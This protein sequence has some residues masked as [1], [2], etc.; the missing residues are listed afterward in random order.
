MTA[1]MPIPVR[2]AGRR[3]N[4]F[5]QGGLPACGRQFALCSEARVGGELVWAERCTNLARGAGDASAA[6]QRDASAP[7]LEP[8]VTWRLP[9]I[10]AVATARSPGTST[11]STSTR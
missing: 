7:E 3:M 5:A 9:A 4:S 1:A 2:E 8:T 11:R 6:A 10:W